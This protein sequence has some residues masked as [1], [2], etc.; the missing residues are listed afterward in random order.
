VISANFDDGGDTVAGAVPVRTLAAFGLQDRDSVDPFG[1]QFMYVVSKSITAEA[2]LYTHRPWSEAGDI[3]VYDG[4]GSLRTGNATVLVLSFGANGHG[5]Y[6]S[7]G[8]R[9]FTSSAHVDEWLNCHCNT[10]GVTGFDHSF[11]LHPPS[12]NTLNHQ[13]GFD[14]TGRYY[15]RSSFS[16][17]LPWPSPLPTP[18]PLPI[19][20]HLPDAVVDSAPDSP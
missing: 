2:A 5:A 17:T 12:E 9:K 16:W 3:H 13:N 8:V 20:D 7:S 11:A 1:N 14:D 4:A 6:Q 18:G 15:K 10:T 19:P